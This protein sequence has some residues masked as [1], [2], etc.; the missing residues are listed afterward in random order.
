VTRNA[1]RSSTSADTIINSPSLIGGSG[2]SQSS[3][4]L[5]VGSHLR[6]DGCSIAAFKRKV[7]KVYHDFPA[8]MIVLILPNAFGVGWAELKLHLSHTRFLTREEVA[9]IRCGQGA[10][11]NGL[12]SRDLSP[13]GRSTR[14]GWINTPESPHFGG[15]ISWGSGI[16][17]REIWIL[18]AGSLCPQS[19]NVT[20]QNTLSFPTVRTIG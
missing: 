13:R 5:F 3:S 14:A 7:L 4:E 9:G 6:T 12:P 11:D 19:L 17:T 16:E 2:A 18:S 10:L 20:C 1:N 8:T 15:E